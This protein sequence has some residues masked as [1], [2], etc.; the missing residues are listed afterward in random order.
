MERERR[1]VVDG[2]YVDSDFAESEDDTTPA[3]AKSKRLRVQTQRKESRRAEDKGFDAKQRRMDDF[4]GRDA[5]RVPKKETTKAVDDMMSSF[6]DEMDQIAVNPD[7]FVHESTVSAA[8]PV[9]APSGPAFFA[10]QPAPQEAVQ[11]VVR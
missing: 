1:F 7:E 9:A 10:P 2:D 6:F 11:P 3:P 8:A 4:S 5:P